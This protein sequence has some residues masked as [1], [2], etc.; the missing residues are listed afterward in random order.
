MLS[1]S[2]ALPFSSDARSVV[3]SLRAVFSE[4]LT[5]V[6]ADPRGPQSI[7]RR[8]GL[9]KNLT[10]K[11]SKIIQ[12]DDP[13]VALQQMPGASGLNM[14]LQSIRRAGAS[15]ALLQA[16]RD[17]IREYE[18]LIRVHSGDRA[19]LE[20]MGSALSR[21]GRRQQDVY[22][23]KQLFQGASYV[24]GAQTRVM[25]KVGIVGPGDEPGMLDF[26]CITGLIDF[27][28]FRPDVTWLMAARRARNDDGTEIPATASEAIDRRYA[29]E[30]QAP[31]MADFC[32]QPLPELRRFMDQVGARF[33]LV[34]GPVGNT[35]AL[36]CV[37][38]TIQHR[39]PCYRMPANQMGEHMA[40]CDTPAELLI[41]DLFIHEQFAF[42]LPP[43]TA[44]YSEMGASL[45][46][47][48]RG[49]DRNRLP[50]HEPLHDLGSGP[51][52]V[53]TPEVR[54]YNQ[55]VQAMFDRVGWVP[56]EFHGF[57]MK[58]AYPACPTALVMRYAL[59]TAP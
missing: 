14:F 49:R 21:A 54:C 15:P 10:W 37:I 23:R 20:I 40:A 28:R 42:P 35:G 18:R 53:A 1:G 3:R 58:V 57:R 11:I 7:S 24:W 16:A 6:G 55:M 22:H 31:L 25:L 45:P 30:D 19:T 29:G 8:F 4:L 51:L 38:G 56:S 43:E 52:P 33:E 17:A 27:R 34:E 13:S 47:P 59:P 36:T 48:R 32:S 12:T 39:L 41:F 46:Y 50:L 5:S 2:S 26:A 9:N 44:L